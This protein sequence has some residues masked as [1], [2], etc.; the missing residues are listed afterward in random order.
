MKLFGFYRGRR[1]LKDSWEFIEQLL[2]DE[3][4][5]N[6]RDETKKPLAN[7]LAQIAK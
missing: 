7:E 6:E 2:F 1:R 5:A 3:Q 4:G